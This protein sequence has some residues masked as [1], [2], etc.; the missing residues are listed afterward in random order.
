VLARL[1][2]SRPLPAG[3]ALN[4]LA[5]AMDQQLPKQFTPQ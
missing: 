1:S 5:E 3:E 4:D 2:R